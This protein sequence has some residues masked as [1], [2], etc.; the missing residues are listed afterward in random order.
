MFP[1]NTPNAATLSS[2]LSRDSVFGRSMNTNRL[3][4]KGSENKNGQL[5]TCSLTCEQGPSS[6]QNVL[7]NGWTRETVDAAMALTNMAALAAARC[8]AI[9]PKTV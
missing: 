7:G 2:T 5:S 9:P 8:S 4:I 3:H 1:W 6:L